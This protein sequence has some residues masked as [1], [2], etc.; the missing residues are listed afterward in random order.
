M[1]CNFTTAVKAS[2]V[3]DSAPK[4]KNVDASCGFR[5]RRKQNLFINTRKLGTLIDQSNYRGQN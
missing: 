5:A 2:P 4:T 3:S 1:V